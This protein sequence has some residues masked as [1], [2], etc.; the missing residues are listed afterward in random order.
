MISKRSLIVLYC[1]APAVTRTLRLDSDL[2]SSPSPRNTTLLLIP[3]RRNCPLRPFKS[4][5]PGTAAG[6]HEHRHRREIGT[7]NF[8][9]YIFRISASS[10]STV[11]F[12]VLDN[13]KKTK[14]SG[15]TTRSQ[16]SSKSPTHQ[17]NS[18]LTVTTPPSS[19]PEWCDDCPHCGEH[20]V[21]R[22]TVSHY[23]FDQLYFSPYQLPTYAE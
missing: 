17:L 9:R 13:K 12:R 3:I 8:L 19:R 14:P 22:I 4:R 16:L 5:V 18:H 6:S 7:V 20:I 2:L 11:E 15:D 21:I 23:V 10:I 1:I